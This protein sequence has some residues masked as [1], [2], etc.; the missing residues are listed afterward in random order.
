MDPIHFTTTWENIVEFLEDHPY[1][2]R[3]LKDSYHA[4][5]ELLPEKN[6]K[7]EEEII[8]Y[9]LETIKDNIRWNNDASF[10]ADD[11]PMEVLENGIGN[12]AEI[13]LML[14]AK[15]RSMGIDAYPVA[16][17]TVDNGFLHSERPTLIQWNYL[18]A[19]ARLPNDNFIL[20]DATVPK[21]IPGYLPQRAINRKGRALD[22]DL[23]SWVNLEMKTQINRQQVYQLEINEDGD[24]TGSIEIRVNDFGKYNLIQQFA[25]QDENTFWNSLIRGTDAQLSNRKIIYDYKDDKP[26][27]I[28]ADIHIPSYALR[29]GDELI[30]PA[31]F[32]ETRE[33]NEFQ[34]EERLYPVFFDN[35]LN[36]ITRIHFEIPENMSIEYLPENQNSTW[37]N[38]SFILLANETDKGVKITWMNNHLN[39]K[40]QPEK[41]PEFRSFYS[42]MIEK[43]LENIIL[44]VE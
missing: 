24:I 5:N 9:A 37:E 27:V 41:Y 16:V 43:N 28:S 38:S 15:L 25:L 32:L 26:V 6:L 40:I 4:I 7:D 22:P 42:Q 2:G 1:F 13:N 3:Y 12:S 39:R 8:W 33:E 35:T 29:I 34:A 11:S 20:L 44:S 17:S 30:L 36:N 19:L 23:N 10:M 21:P 31:L 14:V 18:V